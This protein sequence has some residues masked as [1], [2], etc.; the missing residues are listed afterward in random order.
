[1]EGLHAVQMLSVLSIIPQAQQFLTM[2]MTSYCQHMYPC[3]W[4]FSLKLL[5]TTLPGPVTGPKH[6]ETSTSEEQ[7][8]TC[9]LMGDGVHLRLLAL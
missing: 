5:I 8:S 7:P 4:G 3:S 1:M 9:Q 6:Q 2:P